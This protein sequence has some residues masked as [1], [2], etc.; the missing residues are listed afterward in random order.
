MKLKPA[1]PKNPIPKII[2]TMANGDFSSFGAWNGI[3]VGEED[4]ESFRPK[5]ISLG[6]SVGIGLGDFGL[7]VGVDVGL[8]VGVG[9]GEG[10]GVGVGEGLGIGVGGLGEGV[11]MRE[12]VGVLLEVR[13]IDNVLSAHVGPLPACVYLPTFKL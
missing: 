5:T 12:G 13:L 9:V 3:G 2:I 10:V 7:I 8:G 6:I 11:G 4:I 1:T